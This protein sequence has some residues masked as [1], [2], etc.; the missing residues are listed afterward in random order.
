[1]NKQRRE[2]TYNE[3][4]ALLAQ[5]QTNPNYITEFGEEKIINHVDVQQENQEQNNQTVS[6]KQNK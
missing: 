5:T 4:K 6:K 3:A 2:L 1:M